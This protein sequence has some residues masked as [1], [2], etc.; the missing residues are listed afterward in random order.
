MTTSL[1]EAADLIGQYLADNDPSE[2][3]CACTPDGH[4]CGPCKAHERHQP[5]CKAAYLITAAI[6]AAKSVEREQLTWKEAVLNELIVCHIYN[7]SH[8][9]DPRKAMQDAITCNCQIALDPTVSSDAQALINRGAVESRAEI[10]AK[11]LEEAA[12]ETGHCWRC[13]ADDTL[14]GMAADRRVS[15]PSAPNIEHASEVER[16]AA[17]YRWL[18]NEHMR[19][20][21]ICHLSWKRNWDRNSSYWVNTDDLDKS[22]DAAIG[23]AR[24][25]GGEG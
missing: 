23:A 25:E 21:P 2:F 15:K 13:K 9:N 10:E 17:R 16:D 1:I 18:H 8:D 5:I 11:V 3:G 7:S 12:K 14:N 20:D 24:T 4:I 19:F 22:I 6:E